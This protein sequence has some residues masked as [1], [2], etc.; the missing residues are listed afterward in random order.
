MMSRMKERSGIDNELG[1]VV[2]WAILNTSRNVVNISLT[3]VYDVS[4]DE[5]QDHL[6]I[7]QFYYVSRI[8]LSL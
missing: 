3:N 7:L 1:L 8:T 6:P 4:K 5:V 2:D